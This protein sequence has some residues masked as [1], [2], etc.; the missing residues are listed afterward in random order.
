MYCRARVTS[1]LFLRIRFDFIGSRGDEIDRTTAAESLPLAAVCYVYCYCYGCCMHCCKH[2]PLL[3]VV[4]LLQYCCFFYCYHSS[5][6]CSINRSHRR[7]SNTPLCLRCTKTFFCRAP[8]VVGKAI[9]V[10]YSIFLSHSRVL[11]S[12][13]CC[14]GRCLWLETVTAAF[15]LHCTVVRCLFFFRWPQRSPSATMEGICFFRVFFNRTYLP[16]H[17]RVSVSVKAA[18]C[19]LHAVTL[20]CVSGQRQ[21][22]RYICCTVE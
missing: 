1:L 12:D 14:S 3:T 21:W 20:G 11:V 13:F 15:L 6:P 19:S 16:S 7:D 10:L 5:P 18:P 22:R 17:P 8:S 2:L 4:V 9:R